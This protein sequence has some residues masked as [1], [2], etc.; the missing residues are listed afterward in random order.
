MPETIEA[1]QSK[2]TI[3]VVDDEPENRKVLQF[4]LTPAGYEVITAVDGQEALRR[5]QEGGLDLILLD[6]MMP[7]MS[8]YEVCARIKK[9]EK[10]W[11]IPVVLVTSLRDVEDKIKGIEAGADDF[12]S[13]PVNK[14]E[15]L[16]RVKSLVRLK[17]LNDSLEN[18]ESVLFVLA[19]TV[20]AKDPYTEGHLSR[21]AGYASELARHIGLPHEMETA[22]KYAGIL[23]DIGKIGISEGILAKPGP[24]TKEEFE[25]MKE[26]VLFGERIIKPLRF[27]YL[28]APAVRGHHEKWDGSGYPD[29]LKGENIP[30]GARILSI[31]DA[32]DAMTTDRPYRRALP[33]EKAIQ[34]LREGKATQ[35]DANLVEKFI[36]MIESK[37]APGGGEGAPL[38]IFRSGK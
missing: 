17:H 16:A 7:Q 1:P 21:M 38:K 3:L 37:A 11:F 23:H 14:H 33:R 34:T 15:L 12:L 4:H 18:T 8:G 2:T 30:I 36:E 19:E 20:E 31:V 32:Y 6:V 28:V 13:K 22:L 26:H 10:T 5:I 29:G 27:A 25:T 35:W 9:D 24:L